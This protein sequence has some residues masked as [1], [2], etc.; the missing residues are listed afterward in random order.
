M[1]VFRPSTLSARTCLE[2]GVNDRETNWSGTER[3]YLNP[4]LFTFVFLI[5][6][7]SCVTPVLSQGC[8][9]NLF[10]S[11]GIE[12]YE[13]FFKTCMLY[14]SL[15]LLAKTGLSIWFIEKCNWRNL[16]LKTVAAA[17]IT[18]VLSLL[19]HRFL[20]PCLGAFNQSA[21]HLAVLIGLSA[22]ISATSSEATVI[23]FHQKIS[24]FKLLL[25]FVGNT[26]F[27]SAVIALICGYFFANLQKFLY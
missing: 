16:I 11:E 5:L 15:A 2:N 14:F 3:L 4:R 21:M 23:A 6:F 17:F 18:V 1:V 22:S 8:D 27:F 19:L 9:A 7:C 10:S 20:I 12:R 26:L 13:Q 24:P 25:M